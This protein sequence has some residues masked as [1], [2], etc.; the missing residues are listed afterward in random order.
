MWATSAAPPQVFHNRYGDAC[1]YFHF[2]TLPVDFLNHKR[3]FAVARKLIFL[4]LYGVPAKTLNQAVKRNA[5]RFPGDFMFQLPTL[6]LH[7]RNIERPGHYPQILRFQGA[8]AG[9]IWRRAHDAPARPVTGSLPC[10]PRH[11]FHNILPCQLGSQLESL[12]Y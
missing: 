11:S 5:S 4:A 12:D 1:E 10:T 3:Y 7:S 8:I 6:L 9:R 2:N